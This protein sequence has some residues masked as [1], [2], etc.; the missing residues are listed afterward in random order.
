VSLT[1]KKK[2]LRETTTLAIATTVEITNL[3]RDRTLEEIAG[4]LR[5]VMPAVTQQFSQVAGIVSANQYNQQ[6][7][8][9]KVDTE[10]VA[11]PIVS[12]KNTATQAAVGFGIAQLA[13]GVSYD[14]FQSTL[15]GNV[16]RLTLAGDRETVELNIDGDPSG[17]LYE[18]VPSPNACSFC[19]T[20]AAVAEVQRSSSFDKYH[21]F[22]GCTL[23]PIFSGQE[24]TELPVY[25]QAREAYSLASSELERRRE[26]VNWYSMKTR[27]AAKL[28]P[29]LTQTTENRLRLV[30]EITGWK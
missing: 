17:T 1:I 5:K 22:C 8:S 27:Q 23:N 9:A 16:Q 18:R 3:L 28:Y 21:A 30:R 7:R 26:E 11:V 10:Y 14:T 25:K 24:R 2:Q 4:Q 6:R 19:L 12:N 13:S 15:A 29:D 20:M